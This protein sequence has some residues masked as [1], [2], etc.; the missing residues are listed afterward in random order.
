MLGNVTCDS[1][2]SGGAL[3]KDGWREASDNSRAFGFLPVDRRYNTEYI[4]SECK[5]SAFTSTW[6]CKAVAASP[7]SSDHSIQEALLGV[8]FVLNPLPFTGCFLPAHQ[9]QVSNYDSST[10][11]N[12]HCERG[13]IQGQSSKLS[14]PEVPA[15]QQIHTYSNQSPHG[16]NSLQNGKEL[17]LYLWQ[18][19][20][21]AGRTWEVTWKLESET[22]K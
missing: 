15:L 19:F 8:A 6:R 16:L 13:W 22:K 14:V 20:R 3:P 2:P 7:S 17:K 11:Q 21:E 4:Q 5:I 1:I 9:E 10:S 18:F 12:A